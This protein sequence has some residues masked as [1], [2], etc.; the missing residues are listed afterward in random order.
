MIRDEVGKLGKALDEGLSK[1]AQ[2]RTK[3]WSSELGNSRKG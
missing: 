2:K 1:V 3:A